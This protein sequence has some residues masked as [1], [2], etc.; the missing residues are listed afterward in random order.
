MFLRILEVAGFQGGDRLL[1]FFA[2][3]GR[4]DTILAVKIERRRV[5]MEHDVQ[6]HRNLRA[7]QLNFLT[8]AEIAD[9]AHLEVI[10]SK[11]KVGKSALR[12]FL[13][14][15]PGRGQGPEIHHFEQRLTVE[16][17][18]DLFSEYADDEYPGSRSRFVYGRQPL[19]QSQ[20]SVLPQRDG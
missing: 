13:G 18:P 20:G 10:P 16:V 4:N 17:C 19:V 12:I 6:W 7:G 15:I 5:A 8:H 3:L 2:R 9:R 11:G 1:G 14:R